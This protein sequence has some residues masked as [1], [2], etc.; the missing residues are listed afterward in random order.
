MKYAALA[1]IFSA[2]LC[3]ASSRCPDPRLQE[4]TIGG[5]TITGGVVTHKKAVRFIEVRLYSSAGETAWVGKT[6]KDGWFRTSK[7]EAGDYR[8]EIDKWG[9]TTIHL[10]PEIDKGFMQKPVWEL[11]FIDNGCVA[12]IQIMN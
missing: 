2:C 3:I 5:N 8:I 1:V 4:V 7:L 6:D 12:Y 11:L 9:S 10:N